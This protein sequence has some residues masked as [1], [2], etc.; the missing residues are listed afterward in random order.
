M[1]DSGASQLR[2]D[3]RQDWES[4]AAGWQKWLRTFE[5]GA[6]KMSDRLIEMAKIKPGSKVLD[7]ATGIGEPAITVAKFVGTR[8]HVLATDTSL[9][10]LSVAR[11]RAIAEDLEGIIDFKEGDAAT[12]DLP[13]LSFDSALCRLGLMFLDDL[14]SGLVNINKSLV[15]GGRFAASVWATSEKVPQL[16]LAMNTVRKELNISSPPPLGTPGPFSLADENILKKSFVRC[17]FKVMEIERINIAF[18]F[19]SATE[20]TN[21]TKDIAAPV[22]KMLNDQTIERKEQIWKAITE[23][24][25]KYVKNNTESIVLHN[26]AI[27]IVGEKQ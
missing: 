6:Y 25:T 15:N 4:V 12:I 26:E 9:Q 5:N 2:R 8:G 17:G 23:E 24:A 16:A 7:I 11:N 21:F 18:E 13:E 10:M 20:Y 3:Q 22:L 27:C 19:D 14:D 1:P